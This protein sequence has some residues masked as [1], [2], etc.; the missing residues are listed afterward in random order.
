MERREG[1]RGAAVGSSPTGLAQTGRASGAT[2]ESSGE[3]DPGRLPAL[4]RGGNMSAAAPCPSSS[5]A[6]DDA[7]KRTRRGNDKADSGAGISFA[8]NPGSQTI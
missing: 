6:I 1:A 8:K 3:E 5:A 7:L 2:H 4:H